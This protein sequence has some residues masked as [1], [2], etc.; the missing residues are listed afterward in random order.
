[1]KGNQRW[2]AFMDR[3]GFKEQGEVLEGQVM[4]GHVFE[5][6]FLNLYSIAFSKNA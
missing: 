6:V 5:R 4:W 3:K 1:M 2:E